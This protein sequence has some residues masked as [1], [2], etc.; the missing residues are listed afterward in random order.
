MKIT[1]MILTVT[2]LAALAATACSTTS[3]AP[4]TAPASALEKPANVDNAR[5][6][7]EIHV[8]L[9]EQLGEDALGLETTVE[10]SR[11][12]LRGKV[13]ERSSQELA[14]EIALSVD[15]IRFVT[16]HIVTT[17][18]LE[19]DAVDRAVVDTEREVKDAALEARVGINLLSEIGR[20]A[21]AVEVES[22]D[23]VVSLRGTLPDEARKELALKAAR[24]TTGVTKVLDL[25]KTKT[26]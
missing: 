16:N 12:T 15:G 2:A 22:T 5:R 20:Y 26:E 21:L 11:A 14:K 3:S 8:A 24:K 9:L 6:A 13:H 23:G 18:E 1:P 25:L 17:E 4:A 7:A 19:G 10:G